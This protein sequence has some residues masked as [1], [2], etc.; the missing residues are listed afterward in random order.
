[1]SSENRI[2]LSV[3][4]RIGMEELIRLIE[5]KLAGG[6]RECVLLIPYTD[7]RAVAYLNEHAV[8]YETEYREEGVRM[9]VNCRA[10]DYGYYGKYLISDEKVEG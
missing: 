4:E 7:G 8:V 3:R 5:K 2:Y 10:Q 9:R 1:M 6:Y